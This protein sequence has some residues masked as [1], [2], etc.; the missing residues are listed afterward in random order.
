MIY[1]HFDI[2]GHASHGVTELRLFDPFAQ[3]A[4]A[5]G[6]DAVIGL[7]RQMDGKT[8]GIYAGVP[9]RPSTGSISPPT[10]A[11]GTARGPANRVDTCGTCAR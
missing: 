8:A 6:P 10:C 9:P 1:R 3:V 7:C 5:D 11:A 2:L 4:Y